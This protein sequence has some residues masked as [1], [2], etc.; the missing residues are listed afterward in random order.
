MRDV[1]GLSSELEALFERA[2]TEPGAL[3]TMQSELTALGAAEIA[4]P[5]LPLSVPTR[6]LLKAIQTPR[7]IES[8]LNVVRLSELGGRL[9][10]LYRLRLVQVVPATAMGPKSDSKGEPAASGEQALPFSPVE[11]AL[12]S[13]LQES[14]AKTVKEHAHAYFRR[15]LGE[16]TLPIEAKIAN[17]Q[18]VEELLVALGDAQRALY[19]LGGSVDADEFSVH[20]VRPLIAWA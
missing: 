19:D 8:L 17:A 10:E 6:R 15:T 2:G 12:F 16:K 7:T 11:K 9:R 14:V 18:T 5:T 3:S 13:P 20:V 1:R 4:R